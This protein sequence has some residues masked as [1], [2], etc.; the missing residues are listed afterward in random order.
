MTMLEVRGVTK[1]F[2]GFV[3]VR[4]VSLAVRPG[5]R[6]AIIGPNGAG[7]TTLFNLLSGALAPDRGSVR[8]LGEDIGR[9]APHAIVRLG[10]ARSFQRVNIFPRKTVADNI[11]VACI[12]RDRRHF[13]LFEPANGLYAE[14][15]AALLERV[16]L[17]GDAGL[18]AGELAYGRQKQLELALALAARPKLLMLDEPT[19]GMS[20]AETRALSALIARVAG[21][22]GLTL[23]F[24]EHDM[25]VVFGLA[26][27]IS[28]LHHGRIIAEGTPDEV[29]RHPEVKNVYLGH[30][31]AA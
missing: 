4:D 5:A 24:T 8:F 11:V 13:R 18:R 17:A 6:H 14:E 10:L 15:S 21:E 12:A 3:A 23:L 26:D 19:A 16:G 25:S 1:A 30:E 27:R 2:D 9:L 29:R 22:L 20:V 28:V 7:K 31:H